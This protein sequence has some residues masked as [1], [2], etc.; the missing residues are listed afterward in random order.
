MR[1]HYLISLGPVGMALLVALG[2]A[3]EGEV[4]TGG[5][6]GLGF[7]YYAIYG[8]DLYLVGYRWHD[9]FR[10]M[11]LNLVLI[12]VN[13][14]GMLASFSHGIS[15]SKPRFSR[16]PKVRDRTPVPAR[17][18]LAEFVLLALWWAQVV[19]NLARGAK[20]VPVFMLIHAMLVVY[21]IRAFIGY[22]NSVV[23][24][25]TGARRRVGDDLH[26]ADST[27]DRV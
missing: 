16:T 27:A 23:D 26:A 2:V 1:L 25:I 17:Y 7:V 24:I 6:L 10:V 14:V 21:A 4:R 12:P 22:R 20:M 19:L 9:I 3:W 5:L 18:L 8:R 13:I 15:G 11:A